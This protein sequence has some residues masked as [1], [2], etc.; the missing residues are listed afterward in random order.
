MRQKTHSRV[1]IYTFTSIPALSWNVAS[2]NHR[3]GQID[4]ENQADIEGRWVTRYTAS[5]CN[6]ELKGPETG[7][8]KK[9][10]GPKNDWAM[11]VILLRSARFLFLEQ[12]Q[13]NSRRCTEKNI[14]RTNHK[15]VTNSWLRTSTVFL[16]ERSDFLKWTCRRKIGSKWQ[17][18]AV[19][20]DGITGYYNRNPTLETSIWSGGLCQ[21][22][23]HLISV[24][25][26]LRAQLSSQPM[27][28]LALKLW[29]NY[30]SHEALKDWWP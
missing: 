16:E 21:G 30:R 6:K 23:H 8:K 26:S 24:V 1:T 28:S 11:P 13:A 12:R 14:S 3:T 9:K 7:E 20:A 2:S 15:K 5:Q 29:C 4:R 18:F 19:N 17:H 10:L 25:G 27:A 22:I